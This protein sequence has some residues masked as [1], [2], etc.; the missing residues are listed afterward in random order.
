MTQAQPP[1]QTV[2]LCTLGRLALPENPFARPK[3]LLLLAYLALEGPKEKRF[4]AELF[5]PESDDRSSSLRQ[6][7]ARLRSAGAGTI[8]SD[9]QRVWTPLYSD[10][11]AFLGL[12]EARDLER[13]A[14]LYG[15]AFLTGVPLPDLGVELEEWVYATREFLAGALRGALLTLAEEASGLGEV[16]AATRY[17]ERAY[18]AEGAP[19]LE[20]EA[21]APL[22]ALLAAGGSPHAATL[23]REA[24]GYDL[25]LSTPERAAPPPPKPNEGGSRLPQPLTQLVGRAGELAELA[26]LLGQ[27]EVRLLSLLGPGG[28]GKTRL[29]L[30]LARGQADGFADGAFFVSLDLLEN[31]RRLPEL[32]ARTVGLHLGQ[33]EEA[34][35][36]VERFL[37]GKQVLLLLDG[38]ETVVEA[39]GFL[40]RLL[41]TSPGLKLLLTTRERFGLVDEWVFVLEGLP[42]P[43]AG[44]PPEG[45]LRYDAVHLFI[46]RAKH[47]DLRFST[48]PET[49]P[50][51][52]RICTLVQGFPLGIALAA[53]WV[54]L[55]SCA[56]I[57]DEIGR[58]TD[59]LSAE[60]AA[61]TERHRSIR[62]VFEGSWGRLKPTERAALSRLSVFQGGFK[63]EA[64]VQVVGATLPVLARLVDV[65]L[66]RVLPGGRFDRHPLLYQLTREKLA[67]R[68]HDEAAA[69]AAHARFYLA[70]AAEAEPH[71][72]TAAQ[73]E[74]LDGLEREHDNLRAALEWSLGTPERLEGAFGAVHALYTFWA[75]RAHTTEARAWLARA[76]AVPGVPDT[77]ARADALERAGSLAWLQ[78]D[79]SEAKRYLHEAL[80]LARQLDAKA[81]VAAALGTLGGCAVEEGQHSDAQR[82]F[83]ES[84]GLAEELRDERGAARILHNLGTLAMDQGDV[85]TAEKRFRESLTLF[86]RL[87]SQHYVAWT[88]NS[89]ASAVL[90][91]GDLLRAQTHAEEALSLFGPAGDPIGRGFSHQHLGTVA[92]A[93][94][95]RVQAHAH[96]CESL[97][98]QTKA[99]NKH[100]LVGALEAAAFLPGD[101]ARTARLLGAA[102]HARST[103]G[104]PRPPLEGGHYLR[105]L[106]GTR[107]ALGDRAFEV[108]WDEGQRLA[109]E[110][111]VVCALETEAGST[112]SEHLGTSSSYS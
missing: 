53:A 29:A 91:Q 9:A 57:A 79:Y 80:T 5:F 10:A 78:G 61:Y 82:L 55:L 71:L 104:I 76:L 19:E 107:A 75:R 98:L 106:T 56:E 31:P 28:V 12:L 90:E 37:A 88:L 64:A 20:P 85:E 111:A 39:G 40:S 35:A 84:L 17:A 102:E 97:R 89:L 32:L 60:G 62:A 27:S 70:L 66:L 6:T 33:A 2:S 7:L 86:R 63:R 83:E 87:D 44:T 77:P 36:Q 13:A 22:Y 100:G 110:A 42:V 8:Q 68:P 59:L 109:L 81:C 94:G 25:T 15:G 34:E 50:H 65:S 105:H 92:D 1:T 74:W 93:R 41:R 30:E 72:S 103:L 43:P 108:A 73:G 112:E 67:E 16:Q 23:R 99:G 58:D 26:H 45:A 47:A 96:H 69:R 14:A 24:E 46:G 4:L 11:A 18:H 38:A 101:A 48:S 3:P 49:L 54:K 21:F 95:E 52:V 51:L